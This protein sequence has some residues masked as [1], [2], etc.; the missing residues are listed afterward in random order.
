M[1]L[2]GYPKSYLYSTFGLGCI[3]VHKENCSSLEYSLGSEK[4]RMKAIGERQPIDTKVPLGWK[5]S[6]LKY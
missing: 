4:K 6:G 1:L 3:S 2:K 5:K